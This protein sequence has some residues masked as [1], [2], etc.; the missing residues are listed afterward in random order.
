MER[1]DKRFNAS[2]EIIKNLSETVASLRLEVNKL[3]SEGFPER[4][5]KPPTI[6]THTEPA[7]PAP[8]LKPTDSFVRC[9]S[10]TASG[11][12]Q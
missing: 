3:S 12:L 4:S 7:T 6:E 2:E 5:T 11:N 8:E 10:E 9:D 1:V